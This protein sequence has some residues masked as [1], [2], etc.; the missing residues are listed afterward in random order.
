[1]NA[2]ADSLRKS[3]WRQDLDA[4]AWHRCGITLAALVPA[5]AFLCCLLAGGWSAKT[6]AISLPGLVVIVMAQTHLLREGANAAR[7]S[8][9]LGEQLLQS[10]KMATIGEMSSGIAH[11][12]N[13]PLNI[14]L[15]EVEWLRRLL[16][17]PVLA[18]APKSGEFR[19]SL[20]QIIAQVSRCSEITHGM[21]NLAKTLHLVEQST[22]VNRLVDDMLRWVERE[23]SAKNIRFERRL[24]RDLPEISTD[25]PMLRQVVLNL[26]NN[27]A[28]AV[29]AGGKICVTTTCDNQKKLRI[30]VEDDGPGIAPEHLQSIFTPFFTTKAPGKGTGLGLSISQAIV[31]RLGGT[32]E[33]ES[34]PGQGALFCVTLPLKTQPAQ[35]S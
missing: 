4:S 10:R 14:I 27:A 9:E 19:D 33:V 30:C 35:R 28:Q 1:M 22:D 6:L 31:A 8:T 23:G 26:L 18:S 32:I 7:S 34:Q 29:E 16:E 13:T 20:E 3:G 24:D 11:E 17:D 15:Q 2:K 12:I 25:A 21:L 5:V